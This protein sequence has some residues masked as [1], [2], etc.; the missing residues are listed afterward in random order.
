[1][2]SSLNRTNHSLLNMQMQLASG[3][4]V[5]R[6][7]D[8]AVASSTISVLEDLIERRGQRMRNLS[9]GESTLNTLDSALAEGVKLVQDARSIGLSQI[10]TGSDSASRQAQ[11]VI[12][13]SIIEQMI[14]IGNTNYQGIQIFSGSAT[15]VSPMQE[16]FGGILYKGQ[17]SGMLTDLGLGRALPITVSAEQPYGPMSNRMPGMRD[18]EPAMTAQTPLSHLHGANGNGISLGTINVNVDGTELIVDLSGVQTVQQV[19]DTLQD[20]IQSVDPGATVTIDPATG[21]A[22]TITPSGGID[23]TISDIAAGTTAGDLGISM[24]FPGG[25]S[26]TGGDIQP[27]LTPQAQLSDLSGMSLPLGTI[28][29]TNANQTR[30]LDLSTAETVQDVIS[31][32]AALNIGVRLE[33][34]EAA[35]RL[36]FINDLSGGV[37]SISEVNGGTTATQLGIRSLSGATLLSDFNHGMGVEI[38]SGTI[39]PVTGDPKPEADVDFVITLKD[40]TEI[41]VDLAGAV[42]VQDVLDLINAAAADEGVNVPADFV[43]GLAADGNGITITDNTNPPDAAT[44]V[45]AVN[46]S[47]AAEHLGIAGTTG[48]DGGATLIGEDRATV[49]VNSVLSHLMALRD[50]LKTDDSAGISLATSKL[51]ADIDRFTQTRAE[52]GAR[53]RRVTD[54]ALREEDLQIQDLSLKSQLQDLDFTEAA[55]RFAVLQQQLQAGLQTASRV[56]SLSLLDF[57][58]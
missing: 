28:R 30:V 52:V 8:D 16:L 36:D 2:L 1:M 22:L 35:D 14:A 53:T 23:V 32:V 15:A 31:A 26:T 57:L 19:I 37:M 56:T 54:A 50:A 21:R 25:A 3:K 10:G 17:G 46:G 40:G 7:S 45:K 20:A 43:A 9:H 55:L 47:F 4:S 48:L 44:T 34:N 29:I 18:L 49:A 39:D 27:M 12:I 42:T 24:T 13:D 51:E 11:A 41:E 58:R 6:P 5:L 33:I 38:R